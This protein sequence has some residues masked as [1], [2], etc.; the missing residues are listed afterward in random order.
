MIADNHFVSAAA[1]KT[2]LQL[3][4]GTKDFNKI[5]AISKSWI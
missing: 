1:T 4:K 2:E 3:V 5:I